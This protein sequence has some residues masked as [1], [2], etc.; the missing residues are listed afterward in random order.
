MVPED[1]SERTGQAA[2]RR[3]AN[4]TYLLK[5][6]KFTFLFGSEATVVGSSEF[7]ER[8][9]NESLSLF[10]LLKRDDV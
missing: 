7:G 9:S 2:R 10:G 3:R 8:R 6:D 4:G 1:A 5:C